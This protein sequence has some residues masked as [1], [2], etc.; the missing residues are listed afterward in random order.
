MET[1]NHPELDE[2]VVVMSSKIN[3]KNSD[4]HGNSGLGGNYWAHWRCSLNI[5][6]LSIHSMFLSR[7][8]GMIP[9]CL[10][11]GILKKRPNQHLVVNLRDPTSIYRE[12]KDALGLD[13]TKE[14]ASSN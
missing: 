14:L 2:W 8:S 3:W 9:L 1:G 7:T 10:F 5:I 4:A 12:A 13:Y 6:T 11:L